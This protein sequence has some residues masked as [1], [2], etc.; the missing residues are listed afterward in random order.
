MFKIDKSLA[1]W[2]G[3]HDKFEPS[4]AQYSNLI[5]FD[6]LQERVETQTLGKAQAL[7]ALPRVASLKEMVFKNG[8][9]NIQA[10]GYIG[11]RTVC[12]KRVQTS[13]SL[14]SNGFDVNTL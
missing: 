11:A 2:Q 1:K 14:S 4:K 7:T 12:K 5:V 9:K 8:V 10:A 13:K 6:R 3:R